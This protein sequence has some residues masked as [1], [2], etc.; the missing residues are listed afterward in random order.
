M[1][2]KWS[3]AHLNILESAHEHAS[4]LRIYGLNGEAGS[5]KDF[6]CDHLV[7]TYGMY[8]ITLADVIKSLTVSNVWWY[9]MPHDDSGKDSPVDHHENVNQLTHRQMWR[10]TSDYLHT[11]SPSYVMAIASELL[12]LIPR[13]ASVVVSDVRTPDHIAWLHYTGG[14]LL[15]IV[16]LDNK[17]L[18]TIDTDAK[19]WETV[20]NGEANAKYVFKNDFCGTTNFDH[21][22]KGIYNNG[23]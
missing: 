6:L 21:F 4:S 12:L 22:F 10:A 18:R 16:P 23:F 15:N 14:I 17:M 19:T 8:K 11:Y 7:E 3:P 5:G 2:E 9:S 20:A 13:G 1:I